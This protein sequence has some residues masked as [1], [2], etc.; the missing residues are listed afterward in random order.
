MELN[1]GD[2]TNSTMWT[3]NLKEFVLLIL[4]LLSSLLPTV[5]VV[6]EPMPLILDFCLLTW[7]RGVYKLYL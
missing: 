1:N 3:Q 5:S 7:I 2:Q 6:L 4:G